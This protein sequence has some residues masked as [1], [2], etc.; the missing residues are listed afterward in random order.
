MRLRIFALILTNLDW[1]EIF[2]LRNDVENRQLTK[3]SW[4]LR[5]DSNQSFLFEKIPWNNL[6]DGEKLWEDNQKN[7]QV[8]VPPD[9]AKT[10]DVRSDHS[11][12]LTKVTGDAKTSKTSLSEK[13]TK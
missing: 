2:R 12:R 7:V 11:E 10:M 13:L 3:L 5:F 8:T 6:F 4:E 9:L 1:R